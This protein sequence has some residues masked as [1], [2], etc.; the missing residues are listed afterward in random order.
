MA[1]RGVC[2][3]VA[4]V[5]RSRLGAGGGR[6]S[7]RTGRGR[8]LAEGGGSGGIGRAIVRGGSLQYSINS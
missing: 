8:R 3:A 4:A 2:G 7:R 6:G 1:V 5:G